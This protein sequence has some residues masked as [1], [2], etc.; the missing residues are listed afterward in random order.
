MVR[1]CPAPVLGRV[2]WA[3]AEA[4]CRAGTV[5]LCGSSHTG[6]PNARL[7]PMSCPR[8]RPPAG[9]KVSFP[10]KLAVSI[11]GCYLHGARVGVVRS[12]GGQQPRAQAKPQVAGLGML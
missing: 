8:S 12:G 4:S 1:P 5:L 6:Q 10:W 9:G 7:L 3:N 2:S 11:P